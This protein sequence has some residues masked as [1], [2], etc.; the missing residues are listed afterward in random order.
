M[1]Q[2]I[3]TIVFAL[4]VLVCNP[5]TAAPCAGFTDVDSAS[6]FCPNVEWLKNRQ[7]TFG[8][9]APS[10]FCPNDYATRVQMAAFMNRLGNALEPVFLHASE[11]GE[12]VVAVIGAGGPVCVTSP[13][14]VTGFP[15]VATASAMLYHRSV[16][17]ASVNAVL[18]YNNGGTAAFGDHTHAANVANFY[19]TQTPVGM[20]VLLFPG[21]TVVFGIDAFND[22]G[23]L[24]NDAGCE[25]TVRL[26]SHTGTSSPY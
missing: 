5:S 21:Q 18:I 7:I 22:A 13:Y 25:L 2:V 15:R 16:G 4:A 6:G 11:S 24:P 23:L 8:C 14:T 26:D 9:T 20:P 12:S 1:R 10:S 17:N 3:G 19:T